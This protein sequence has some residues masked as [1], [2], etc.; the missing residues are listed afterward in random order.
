MTDTPYGSRY[1]PGEGPVPCPVLLIGEGPGAEEDIQGRPFCG[2]SGQLLDRLL[3]QNGLNR[4][5]I[6]V[7]NMVKYRMPDNA[8]PTAADIK[9]DALEL[10]TEI[11]AVAP[12]YIGLLGRF[13]A[14]HFLGDIDLEWAHG[15][16]WHRARQP[17]LMPMYHPAMGLH[18]AEA[19]PFVQADIR[20]FALMVKGKTVVQPR[21]DPWPEPR[22][23]LLKNKMPVL[24]PGPVY[25]DT[26]GSAARPWGLSYTQQPGR[27][28]VI[29]ADNKKLL[30]KFAD[31]LQWT[32]LVVV[33]NAMHD[34]GVLRAMGITL[35][36]FR[37]TM[38][39]AHHLCTE[40][41]GLKPLARRHASMMQDS[42]DDIIAHARKAK[43]TKFFSEALAWLDKHWAEESATFSRASKKKKTFEEEYGQHPPSKK[44]KQRVARTLKSISKHAGP[45]SRKISRQRQVS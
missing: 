16:Q 41:Q 13:A 1:V 26:E 40:P 25:I 8:D 18:S 36:N 17:D 4:D 32:R 39:R 9:R 21:E 37:D 42:Y 23:T 28:Y 45:S 5:Q 7:T 31:A 29:L 15:L 35:T 43:A 22:Y 38:V 33:H 27:A 24:M 3:L 10:K 6:Y 34:I 30:K 20:A 2:K 14:R 44:V 19:L 11:D 12:D